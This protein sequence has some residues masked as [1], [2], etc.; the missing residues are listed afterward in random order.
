MKK[1]DEYVNR[2]LTEGTARATGRWYDFTVMK[3]EF[4][5]RG[6]LNGHDY[7]MRIYSGERLGRQLFE[8]QLKFRGKW[9]TVQYSTTIEEA[10]NPTYAQW[11]V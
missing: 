3:K 11:E 7:H 9:E 5:G 10:M 4:E 6:K 1:F 8:T 2:Y